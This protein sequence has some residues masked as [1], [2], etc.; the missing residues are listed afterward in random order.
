MATPLLYQIQPRAARLVQ[1]QTGGGAARPA[2]TTLPVGDMSSSSDGGPSSGAT[3]W[4]RGHAIAGCGP[5]RRRGPPHRSV[6]TSGEPLPLCRCGYGSADGGNEGASMAPPSCS[7][8]RLIRRRPRPSW[9]RPQR[10]PRPSG[11]VDGGGP[12]LGDVNQGRANP[13]SVHHHFAMH[14]AGKINLI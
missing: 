2:R 5:L 3:R 12:Y 10:R 9:L 4:R 6:G 11:C 8:Q 13:L 1:M 14:L 7:H